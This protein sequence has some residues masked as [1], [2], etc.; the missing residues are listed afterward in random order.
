MHVPA[1]GQYIGENK[2]EGMKG[3]GGGGG[4]SGDISLPNCLP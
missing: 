4:G 3:G 1:L 2:E